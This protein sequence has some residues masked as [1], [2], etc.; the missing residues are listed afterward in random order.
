MRTCMYSC[1]C[2]CVCAHVSVHVCTTCV[3]SHLYSQRWCYQILTPAPQGKVTHRSRKDSI[4]RTGRY[5]RLQL[6][7]QIQWGNVLFSPRWFKHSSR[8]RTSSISHWSDGPVGDD[9]VRSEMCLESECYVLLWSCG[10]CI[11]DG[12]WV[13]YWVTYTQCEPRSV[14]LSQSASNIITT[15]V[16]WCW[17][18]RS[19]SLNPAPSCEWDNTV[20]WFNMC[21]TSG[22]E[23]DIMTSFC[24]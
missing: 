20:V 12:R 10:W 23:K 16:D 5:Y 4:H 15:R 3:C 9:P 2:I 6:C 14:K 21:N 7:V 19:Y 18:K 1:V 8:H 17:M 13:T 22:A 24:F 11:Q